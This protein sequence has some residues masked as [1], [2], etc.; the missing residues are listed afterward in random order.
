MVSHFCVCVYIWNWSIQDKEAFA[1][2]MEGW[3]EQFL[4]NAGKEIRTK[5]VTQAIPTSLCW[6]S[7]LGDYCTIRTLHV[8][9]SVVQSTIYPDGNVLI[10]CN[11]NGW[12][13]ICLQE[14]VERSWVVECW[15]N[16]ASRGSPICRNLGRSAATVSSDRICCTKLGHQATGMF[17]D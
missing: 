12:N 5:A 8:L 14:Y 9:K 16:L 10:I 17:T 1:Y 2:L 13:I 11:E 4:S 6:Q 3:T 15:N 7:R